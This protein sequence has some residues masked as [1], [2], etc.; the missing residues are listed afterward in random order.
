V[1]GTI[2]VKRFDDEEHLLLDKRFDNPTARDA[3]ASFGNVAHI[4]K[5]SRPH[6]HGRSKPRR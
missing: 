2:V 3:A 5:G 1:L 4:R 6:Q